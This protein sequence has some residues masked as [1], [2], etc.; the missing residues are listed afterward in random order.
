VQN[1]VGMRAKQYESGAEVSTALANAGKVRRELYQTASP[2]TLNTC[3][4]PAINRAEQH[5][6]LLVFATL[7]LT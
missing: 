6:T 5:L 2:L 1:F 4:T 3:A 7:G